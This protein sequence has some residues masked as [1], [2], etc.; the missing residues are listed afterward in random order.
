[1]SVTSIIH[2]K[3]E[4]EKYFFRFLFFAVP[5][6]STELILFNS[7]RR[8]HIIQPVITKGGEIE[9]H[10]DSPHHFLELQRLRIRISAQIHILAVSLHLLDNSPCNQIHL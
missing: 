9:L 3:R 6:I 8:D 10:T 7:H 1:M 4:K 5:T 2:H